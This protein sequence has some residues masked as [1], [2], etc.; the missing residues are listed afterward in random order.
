MLYDGCQEVFV[1]NYI[2]EPY[3]MCTDAKYIESDNAQILHSINEIVGYN[4]VTLLASI[5]LSSML[6]TLYMVGKNDI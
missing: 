1:T 6:I 2:F 5:M 3:T 4:I